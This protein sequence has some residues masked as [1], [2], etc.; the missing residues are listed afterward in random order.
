MLRA[1]MRQLEAGGGREDKIGC[2]TLSQAP[3][4]SESSVFFCLKD[5]GR[6]FWRKVDELD[7]LRR[8][9]SPGWAPLWGLRALSPYVRLGVFCSPSGASGH[10]Q[11][12]PLA[13][14]TSPADSQCMGP[15]SGMRAHGSLAQRVS[16]KGRSGSR[17]AGWSG[18]IVYVGQRTL[19]QVQ[20]SCCMACFH[21][22]CF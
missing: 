8:S 15:V 5:S 14:G 3:R 13:G 9:S 17:A 22:R 6:V 10:R 7:L 20:E 21:S 1:L 19:S 16:R 12:C 4:P 11:G 18:S 2:H